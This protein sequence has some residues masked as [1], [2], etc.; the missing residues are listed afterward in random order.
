MRT[1]PAAA[2]ALLLTLSS[3]AP[4]AEPSTGVPQEEALHLR[5]RALRGFPS[6]LAALIVS[7]ESGG[8]V[9]IAPSAVPLGPAAPAG[10]ERA[11]DRGEASAGT[12][13]ARHLLALELEVDG[14]SLLGPAPAA[15][16]GGDDP[17]DARRDVQIAA[18]ALTPEGGVAAF[19]GRSVELD[20]DAVGEAVYA[21]GLE[22]RIPLEVPP[23]RYRLRVLVRD[24][25]SRRYGLRVLP[26]EVPG[27]GPG[28]SGP[29]AES[30][31][32]RVQ[33][34][35][36]AGPDVQLATRGDPPGAELDVRSRPR[37][38]RAAR[39]ELSRAVES[40]YRGVLE[41]LA[42]GDPEGAAEDL[43]R[44]E[45]QTLDDH[46]EGGLALIRE[47]E[48]RVHEELIATDPEALVPVAR[49]H[50]EALRGNRA[51]HRFA[52]AT[53]DRRMLIAAAEGYARAGGE[54]AAPIA[55]AFLAALGDGLQQ[56]KLYR[57]ARSHLLRAVELDAD[58][59]F[60]LLQ[61]ALG[62]ERTGEYARTVDLLERLV[63]AD[64]K[65]PEARLRLGINLVRVGRDGEGLAALERLTREQN[66]DWVLTVAWE[67]VAMARLRSGDPAGAVELLE[68]ARARL[69][70]E[71]R[72]A[73]QLAYALERAGRRAEAH[74]LLAG[75]EGSPDGEPSP[76]HVYSLWPSGGREETEELL[77]QAALLRLPALRR[78]LA[79]DGEA[80]P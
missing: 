48:S 56:A 8:Q 13:E 57:S 59:A 12:G 60:A 62:L 23:G 39:R 69:P 74:R 34:A 63:A 43:L 28:P 18:Y 72:L 31:G 2:T 42:A 29:L 79:A 40:A 25:A 17:P 52:L 53:H 49:L 55:A 5:T 76:R 51:R 3:P 41:R 70:E 6:S 32:A 80:G 16:A 47:V 54:G 7:G 75:L 1:I 19:V 50:Q 30:W 73:V 20:L 27:D 46:E 64:P 36:T 58:N 78:A 9:L 77:A 15:G 24:P 66:P 35:G 14:P 45:A 65:A 26:L 37:R 67:T 21:G 38:A 61:L 44:I 4:A 68:R 71:Q 11:G 22:I 10:D 33:P